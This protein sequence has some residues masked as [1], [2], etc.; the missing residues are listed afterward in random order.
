MALFELED[1]RL[2]PA[3]FGREVPDGFT[4]D[5]L[6]AV[7]Q[8]VLEIVSRP[9]FPIF[10]QPGAGGD[11]SS[12]RLTALDAA[13]QVVAVE[14]VKLLDADILIDALS[15][16]ADSA[17]M[18][19]TDLAHR[20]P[21]G[22]DGFK[23]G[24]A[25]FR[26]SMPTSPPNGPRMVLVAARITDEV[27]P[28]LDVLSSSGVEVHEMSLRQTSNGR[29]FLEVEPV[30]PRLYS[31][32]FTPVLDGSSPL[33][34]LAEASRRSKRLGAHARGGA[35]LRD[36]LARRQSGKGGVRTSAVAAGAGSQSDDL[37]AT[38]RPSR[39]ARRRRM[40][41][42]QPLGSRRQ[43]RT[44]QESPSPT[45]VGFTPEGLAALT[46]V[47]GGEIPLS[48]RPAARTPRGALLTS[49]G[50]VRVP[51]GSYSDPTEALQASGVYGEDGWTAW[52]LG[53][54]RGPTLAEA[55]EEIS[56]G[57]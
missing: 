1:G 35:E 56:R 34:V 57:H 27:R 18:S 21:H 25:H 53:N 26:E 36:V 5:V 6:H 24:W 22:I 7:R 42:G 14:V 51:A 9:L 31:H 43:R 32:R 28:A 55:I 11:E 3:Q 54:D 46:R 4:E 39:M 41:E 44:A 40:A 52:Y 37:A 50:T 20:Y 2:V 49:D 48:L 19:W 17:A 16:L 38:G 13:G 15:R 8:Q 45:Q 29:A 33:P 30:G 10:W 23:R 47:A 12:P